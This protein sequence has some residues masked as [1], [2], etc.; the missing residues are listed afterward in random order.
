MAEGVGGTLKLHQRKGERQGV[1]LSEELSV[2]KHRKG[3]ED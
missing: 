3:S 2:N 1:K